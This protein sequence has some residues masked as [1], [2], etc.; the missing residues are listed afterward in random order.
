MYGINEAGCVN[1][2]AARLEDTLAFVDSFLWIP[3]EVLQ[4]LIRQYKV[5]RLV[6]EPKR[7]HVV[8]GIVS[9]HQ[10]GSTNPHHIY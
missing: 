9:F 4:H 10:L 6:R 2:N 1:G 8:L 5:K 3:F 7:K